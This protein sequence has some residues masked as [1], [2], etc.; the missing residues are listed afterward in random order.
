MNC[1]YQI[2]PLGPS[3]L[4]PLQQSVALVGRY[5]RRE[6][7]IVLKPLKQ[8]RF[9]HLYVQLEQPK[10]VHQPKT[11]IVDQSLGMINGIWVKFF[12]EFCARR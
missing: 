12:D 1:R 2:E 10:M 4:S 3:H 9:F 8:E 7:V 6:M 5:W 11:K